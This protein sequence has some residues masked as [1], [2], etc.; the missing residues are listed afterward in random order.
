MN[1]S[2]PKECWDT[3]K[4]LYGA[5][6]NAK[7]LMICNKFSHLLMEKGAYVGIFL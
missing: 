4:S 7:K 3:L 5:K 2:D 1:V 6:N